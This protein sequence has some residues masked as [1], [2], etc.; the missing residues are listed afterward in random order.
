[1]RSIQAN[2]LW[3]LNVGLAAGIVLGAGLQV[4]ARLRGDPPP[5]PM[6]EATLVER[7]DMAVNRTRNSSNADVRRDLFALKAG[8]PGLLWQPNAD[9]SDGKVL[10]ALWTGYRGYSSH[11][12]RGCRLG[13]AVWVTPVP[14]VQQACRDFGLRG[15]PLAS[16]LT[17]YLGMRP[18]GDEAVRSV[19]EVW[20]SP[21]SVFRPCPDPDVEDRECNLGM[22][23]L[24]EPPSPPELAHASWFI[25]EYNN[26]YFESL[27][28]WTRLGYT[29]DWG[30]SAD[31]VGA[32]EYVIRQ[33]APIWVASVT[34]T[35]AYCSSGEVGRSAPTPAA[36]FDDGC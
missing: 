27:Y 20:V 26:R 5:K 6:V 25:R 12:D 33:G 30:P 36:A 28:P 22:P 29:Y 35:Q 14:Q 32:S 10:V 16:R 17:Q 9:A 4:R 18:S 2:L 23:K 21:A 8:T 3:W 1:M 7:F 31:H 13:K 19:V 34:D 11:K 15:K 24:S